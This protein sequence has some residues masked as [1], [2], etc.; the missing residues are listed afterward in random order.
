LCDAAL[1]IHCS[2][3]KE[4]KDQQQVNFYFKNKEKG[5][6]SKKKS[7]L[8]C[9]RLGA[10]IHFMARGAAVIPVFPG[11]MLPKV[12]YSLESGLGLFTPATAG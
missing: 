11:G 9:I 5:K 3:E 7:R 8:P 6:L 2:D 4:I 1:I 10:R 12:S